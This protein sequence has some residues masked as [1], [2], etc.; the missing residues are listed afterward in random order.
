MCEEHGSEC[1]VNHELSDKLKATV[2]LLYQA[3]DNGELKTAG[4]LEKIIKDNL[5]VSLE[6][7]KNSLSSYV[8][9][10]AEE[11]THEFVNI[12]PLGDYSKLLEDNDS[13][14]EFLKSE[15]HKAE[16]WKLTEIKL[17]DVNNSLISFVFRNESIDDGDVFKGFVFTSAEGKV[18]HAFAQGE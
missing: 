11:L 13:M 1:N 16:H 5:N 17:S 7:L 2:D 6:E 12:A 15:A 8:V 3:D 14:A 4:I 9:A 18:K 10:S